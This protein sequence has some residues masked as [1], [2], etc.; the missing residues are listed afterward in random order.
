PIMET[1]KAADGLSEGHSQLRRL[2]QLSPEREEN[3]QRYYQQL[4]GY[5]FMQTQSP[6][7][8]SGRQKL[9]AAITA[10]GKQGAM[11]RFQFY[12]VVYSYLILITF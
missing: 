3:L 12:T 1:E 9:S 7:D 4:S 2:P 5:N 8:F 10:K 11:A 6:G